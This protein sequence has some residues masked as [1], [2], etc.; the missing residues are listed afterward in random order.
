MV[1]GTR[2]RVPHVVA[3]ALKRVA[4]GVPRV[5]DRLDGRPRADHDE[6]QRELQLQDQDQVLELGDLALER[7]SVEQH[8]GVREDGE[9]VARE[10]RDG[11]P[12][13]VDEVRKE[14]DGVGA[15]VGTH[16]HRQHAEV[17]TSPRAACVQR[18][19][20][21]VEGIVE[22]LGHNDALDEV[23]NKHVGD[24]ARRGHLEHG[25]E[26]DA[27]DHHALD[28]VAHVAVA[29]QADQQEDGAL[30]GRRHR[31][32]RL[33]QLSRVLHLADHLR[34]DELRAEAEAHD[35]QP[36]E[37]LPHLQGREGVDLA[38]LRHDRGLA[39]RH[40]VGQ[41]DDDSPQQCEDVE[42]HQR[43]PRPHV[44]S[45]AVEGCQQREAEEDEH[46]HADPGFVRHHA[47]ALPP[48]QTVDT[49]D[50]DH[51]GVLG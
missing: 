9:D 47:E 7:R 35:A 29:S 11:R 10:R 44:A 18:G 30:E 12:E 17:P 32:V 16:H 28:L 6:Q 4:V 41:R 26:G 46:G 1:R 37:D 24:Q 15:Q 22:R 36:R 5:H 23:G 42:P 19:V 50:P 25:P 48:A 40:H 20:R 43:L 45:G 38:A 2:A 39:L 33:G 31:A 13:Q 14:G 3:V 8:T 21:C 27:V 34:E 51:E 49:E